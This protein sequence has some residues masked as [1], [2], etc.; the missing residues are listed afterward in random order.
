[1]LLHVLMVAW[2][3]DAM[4]NRRFEIYL[5]ALAIAGTLILMRDITHLDHMHAEGQR[6]EATSARTLARLQSM[7][8]AGEGTGVA[9][10]ADVTLAVTLAS[11][12]DGGDATPAAGDAVGALV[13]ES[14]QR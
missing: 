13:A 2:E 10:P 7:H 5:A 3:G 1:M 4:K 14:G 6:I 12:A 8:G 11:Q 9:F